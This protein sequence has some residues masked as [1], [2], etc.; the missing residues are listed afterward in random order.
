MPHPQEPGL[1]DYLTAAESIVREAQTLL[2]SFAPDGISPSRKPDGSPVT[3]A[4]LAVEDLIRARLRAAFPDHGI[5]G[6]ERAEDAAAAGFQWIID[7]ID[8]TRSF[9]R[10][11]PLY[12]ILLALRHEGRSLVGAM[13]LPGL[14]LVY[15]GALGLGATR[16]GER[17]RLPAGPSAPPDENEIIAIGDRRQFVSCGQAAVFDRLMRSGPI[18]RTYSD[19][20]GHA[21]A[22]DG[23]VGAMVDFDLR[24]WDLAATEVLVRE[25]G[26]RFVCVNAGA[27]GTEAAARYNVVFGKPHVVEWLETQVWPGSG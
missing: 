17:I 9:C 1:R 10:Q 13:A 20:F 26:G 6:E 8:G 21:L 19:C 27:P 3:E 11:I 16:N 7:P 24:I 15:A 22:I 23:R 12:G 18:V 25:A 2:R 14:D 4:D 5:L